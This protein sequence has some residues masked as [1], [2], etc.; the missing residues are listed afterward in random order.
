MPSCAFSFRGELGAAEAADRCSAGWRRR[1]RRFMFVRGRGGAFPAASQLKLNSLGSTAD[2][3]DPVGPLR[4][5]P[6]ARTQVRGEA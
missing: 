2:H 6:P 3:I 4:R 1:R 5:P